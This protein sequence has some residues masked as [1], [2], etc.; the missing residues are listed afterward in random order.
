MLTDAADYECV[1]ENE[2]GKAT[3]VI[4]VRVIEAPVIQ[5]EPSEDVLTVTEGDEVKIACAASGFPKPSVRWVEDGM[6]SP[7]TYAASPAMHYNEAFLEFYRV[8]KSN[9]KTYKCIATNE[10]GTDERYVILNVR[11][12]RGDAPDDSDVDRTPYIPPTRPQ[13]QP[14]PPESVYKAKSGENV[15]LTCDLGSIFV[16]RWERVDGRSLPDNAYTERNMLFI[17]RVNEQNTGLYKCN[18]FNSNG[19][20]ITY[21]ISE[22]VLVPIPQI[23]LH[24]KMPLRV[25]ENDN[26]DILCEVKGEQPIHVSWHA[27]NNR[28]L[29]P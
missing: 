12:R 22:L 17:T 6:E 4:T 24:P 8:A 7:T 13:P 27:D 21:H 16:T 26:I 23:T 20:I 29:P 3:G 5:L 1:A 15:T 28:P 14:I 11:P 25:N 10:A 19:D 2:V 18:A 9:A